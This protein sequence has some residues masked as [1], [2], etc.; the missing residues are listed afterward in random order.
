MKKIIV[1]RFYISEYKAIL[2][3]IYHPNNYKEM[4]IKEIENALY[5]NLPILP[6]KM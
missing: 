1:E 2:Y 5:S 3:Q 6:K 4:L